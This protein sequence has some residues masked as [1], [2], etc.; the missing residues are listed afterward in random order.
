M[1]RIARCDA[2]ATMGRSVI[3]S[4]GACVAAV[5]ATIMALAFKWPLP[6]E[7]MILGLSRI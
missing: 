6:R 1:V 4:A 5:D 7:L 2:S 3:L